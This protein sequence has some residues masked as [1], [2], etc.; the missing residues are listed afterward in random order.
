MATADILDEGFENPAETNGG[1]DDGTW[2][3]QETNGTIGPDETT[4]VTVGSQSCKIT[5]EGSLAFTSRTLASQAAIT[6]TSFYCRYN[7]I[8]TDAGDYLTVVA[9]TD[10]ASAVCWRFQILC[11]TGGDH[12]HFYLRYNTAGN[13]STYSG[14]SGTVLSAD[15]WYKIEIL[16]DATNHLWEWKVDGVSK[17]S[18][19]LADAHG[20]GIKTLRVGDGYIDHSATYYVDGLKISSTGWPTYAPAPAT[21][22]VSQ[23]IGVIQAAVTLFITPFL[24]SSPSQGVSVAEI[25][26]MQV[27]PVQVKATEL[28]LSVA[29]AIQKY[30]T[31]LFVSV[32]EPTILIIESAPTIHPDPLQVYGIE[33]SIGLAEPTPSRQTIS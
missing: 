19:S 12:Y 32:T 26:A 8:T 5:K 25:F 6:Y 28:T 11:H 20:A 13:S 33:L 18:G 1:Y 24:M 27:N 3:E 10:G 7:A 31:P 4:V 22:N 15:T 30:L 17:G 14:D 2:T 16:Y 29:G 21:L 23:G 9:A